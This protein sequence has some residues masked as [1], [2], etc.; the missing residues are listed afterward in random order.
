MNTNFLYI[1]HCKTLFQMIIKQHICSYSLKKECHLFLFSGA[2]AVTEQDL[3]VRS[4]WLSTPVEEGGSL[5]EELERRRAARRERLSAQRE[6]LLEASAG[7]KETNLKFLVGKESSKKSRM[8]RLPSSEKWKSFTIA[9]SA[10]PFLNENNC[11]SSL[12]VILS[13]FV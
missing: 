6:E 9:P 8:G 1:V 12:W 2:Q 4:K 5:R 13:T 10:V 3:D 7:M 11:I